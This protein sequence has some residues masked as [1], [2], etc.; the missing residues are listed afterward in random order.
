MIKQ[1][2]NISAY[3]ATGA[4]SM[5][6]TRQIFTVESDDADAKNTRSGATAS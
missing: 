4:L 6:R 3:L 5:P 2:G 1:K